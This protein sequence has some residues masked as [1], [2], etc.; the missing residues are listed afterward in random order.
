M[1]SSVTATDPVNRVEQIVDAL[2]IRV[3]WSNPAFNG[4]NYD[5]AL[6]VFEALFKWAARGR[7]SMHSQRRLKEDIQSAA[8]ETWSRSPMAARLLVARMSMM[9]SIPAWSELPISDWPIER[10]TDEWVRIKH[11]MAV[12]NEIRWYLGVGGTANTLASRAG[13]SAVSSPGVA[14]QL[15]EARAARAATLLR[16][17]GAIGLGVTILSGIGLTIA[18]ARCNAF[19]AEI[20]E[21]I[22]TERIPD[23]ISQQAWDA[24]E[25][26]ILDEQG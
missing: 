11:V 17:S 2:D 6:P 8:V 24:I 5:H 16:A 4:T 3:V 26:R 22:E 12:L 19:A 14:A 23:E 21:E 10:L 9:Q 1:G 13:Q 15:G 7:F 25:H 20:E 18:V